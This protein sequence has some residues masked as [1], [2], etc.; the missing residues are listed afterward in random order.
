[1]LYI[2]GA[3]TKEGKAGELQ[4]WV[5]ENED[6]LAEHSPEG[7]T[8]RGS[9]FTVHNVGPFDAAVMW[10]IDNYADLDTAREHDDE[11]YVELI[12]EVQDFFIAGSTDTIILREAGDTRIV[13]PE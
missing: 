7:W 5:E 4:E 2:T 8:Y 3:D 11:T 12:R 6:A 1:M 10:E 9:Y 13:E